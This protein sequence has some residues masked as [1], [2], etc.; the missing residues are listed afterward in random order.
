MIIK[1]DEIDRICK[2]KEKIIE[3]FSVW[4]IIAFLFQFSSVQSLSRVQLFWPHESQHT[5][6]P[7]PSPTPGVHS[8]SCPSSRWCQPAISSS[9]VPFSSC[10]QSLPAF[11]LALWYFSRILVQVRCKLP[12]RYREPNPQMW[13]SEWF[14]LYYKSMTWHIIL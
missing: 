13:G 3:I 6:P 14:C 10:P 1:L 8:N 11:C 2:R 5:R 4:K 7:S 9:V 12:V